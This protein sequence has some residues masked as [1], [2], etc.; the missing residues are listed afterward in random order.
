[1][2]N[3][4]DHVRFVRAG[5]AEFLRRSRRALVVF[6]GAGLLVAYLLWRHH[7]WILLGL[8]IAAWYPWACWRRPFR[9]CWVCK[10]NGK[11]YKTD[12][13]GKRVGNTFR[14]CWWCSGTGGRL[15]IG[16]RIYNRYE[17]AKRKAKA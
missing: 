8:A 15:R 17:M 12:K 1:M 6:T 7:P 14:R 5:V 4:T 10:G 11:H 3:G 2:T 16:R 13:D 9:D